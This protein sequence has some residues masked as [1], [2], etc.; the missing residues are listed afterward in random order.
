MNAE[1]ILALYDQEQRREVEYP[2]ARREETPQIVRHVALMEHD[3]GFV[4]YSQVNSSN[5]E[6]I[7]GE[8]IAYFTGI[9]QDFEWK[10]YSHDTPPD[11]KDRLE[12]LGFLIGESEAVMALELDAASALLLEPVSQD[13]RRITTPQKIG[14]VV[15]VQEQVWD[16]DF[17]GLAERL[18]NDLRYNPEHLSVY[19]AYEDNSPVS[20]A[21]I[22]F[23]PNSQFA[24]LWGGSTLPAYR[25]RGLY[26]ALLAVRLQEAQQRGVRF[27]TVDAGPMS[28]PILEKHGFQKITTAYAC[29]WKVKQ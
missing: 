13:V 24:S 6:E 19:V 8:Q 12:A 5:A 27:L 18:V 28:Q 22:Y 21:W 4:L 23:H 11:L 17:G 9:G 7:I 25:E 15:F 2:G 3:Q 29:I 1:E 14:D 26:T 16:T 10:L 20:T